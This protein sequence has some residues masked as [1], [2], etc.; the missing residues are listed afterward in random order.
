MTC[1]F[2]YTSFELIFIK[3]FLAAALEHDFHDFR[4]PEEVERP[5]SLQSIIL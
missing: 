4:K 1:L 5:V 2:E 3:V